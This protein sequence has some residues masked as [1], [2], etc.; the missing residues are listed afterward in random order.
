MAKLERVRSVRTAAV[1]I[2]AAVIAG[3]CSEEPT[4][5]QSPPTPAF[6][7]GSI[8]DAVTFAGDATATLEF[9]E[10]CKVWSWGENNPAVTITVDVD[11]HEDSCGATQ[12]QS[13]DTSFDVILP[14][15]TDDA[16]RC[17]EAWLHGGNQRDYV[18]FTEQV[19]YG[20][21]AAWTLTSVGNPNQDDSGTGGGP[22]TGSVKGNQGFLV[23]FT[24]YPAQGCTPGY[25]KQEHHFDSW[26]GYN[27]DDLFDDVFGVAAFPGLT[28]VEVMWLPGYGKY[29]KLNKLGFH[30]VAA[31][32]NS[33]SALDFGDASGPITY[34]QIIAAFQAAWNGSNSVQNQQKDAFEDLNERACLLN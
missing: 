17:V 9:A 6:S 24:N 10:V 5:I 7:V 13:C 32:L 8:P 25:W 31:L 16:N 20:Y 1:I 23:E 12:D 22:V 14:D 27:P 15:D 2:A 28:L 11:S 3:A 19:P 34:D 21:A 33:T 18:S 4:A 26:V 30:A 29:S